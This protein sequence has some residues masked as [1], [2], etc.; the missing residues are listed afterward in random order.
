MSQS[1]TSTAQ[2]LSGD[3]QPKHEGGRVRDAHGAG[4]GPE[5]FPLAFR[6][7]LFG[8]RHCFHADASISRN[9]LWSLESNTPPCYRCSLV[10]FPSVSAG[11]RN[12]GGARLPVRIVD[13][14]I[15]SGS[16]DGKWGCTSGVEP[17]A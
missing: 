14:S 10:A 12:R 11:R 2:E 7:I 13:L 15:A 5:Y 4:D 6:I 1:W 9:P 17:Y 8:L 16:D 3:E